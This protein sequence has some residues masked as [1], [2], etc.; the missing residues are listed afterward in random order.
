M[1]QRYARSEE[2]LVRAEKTI[3]LGS[4]TFSKSRTQFPHGVSPYFVTRADGCRVWDADGNEYIDMISSLASVTLGYND[5]D[6][7]AAVKAQLDDGVIFSLPHQLEMEVAERIVEMVPSAEKVR[8]GKNGSDAT[9]GAVRLARAF[10]GRDHIAVCGYHGWQDW[11][12]GSTARNQ[13]VPQAVRDLTHSFPYNDLAALETLL[14]AHPDAFAG[15][16]MEPMNVF[17]PEPGYLDGVKALTHAHGALLI[18][19]ETITGF[20]YANGGAQELFGVMPDL[21]TFGK[22]IANGYPLA[23]VAGRND[24]MKLM[25]E[26]FFSFTMGGEALSL[27]AARATMDK[28][29]REPV[30]ATLC[31]RGQRMLD[32]TAKLIATHEL[33]DCLSTSGHPSWGFV[34][35]QDAGGYSSVEIKTLFMQEMQARGVLSFATHNLNYAHQDTDIDQVLRVYNEVF[36]I[37]A[38]AIHNRAM[39]Q[40]LKCE[41]LVPLFKV[42]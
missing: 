3:P 5:P 7:T 19:D 25:E 16:V 23:A 1:S 30:V 2:L 9:A 14:T 42:R 28:L 12:I 15:I 21:S 41:P 18:F 32:E 8:F 11:Y 26:I 27:A 4:Q 40:Y 22:G 29:K 37:L 39:K 6:V 36:P 34:L 24:V 10:T 17:Y 31:S 33:G 20:R 13:G 35:M 38:D